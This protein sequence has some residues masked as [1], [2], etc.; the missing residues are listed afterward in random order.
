MDWPAAIPAKIAN[1]ALAHEESLRIRL[2][3][4]AG[5]V[6]RIASGP[7]NVTFC[8]GPDGTLAE[9]AG[10]AVPT[11]VLTIQPTDIAAL[12]HDPARF[13]EFVR[14]E[15]DAALAATIRDVSV[16]MP[17][18]VEQ[19][20]SDAFGAIAG[21]RLADAGRSLLGL[22]EY[23]ASRFH[24]SVASYVRDEAELVAGDAD[25]DAFG[26]DVREISA[27]VDDLAARIDRIAARKP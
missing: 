18:F 6:F 7:A 10:D 9:G 24:A 26:D 8:V 13:G 14:A 22:P 16:T 2:A 11:L 25:V 12:L 15:G 21:Q 20:F 5:G 19:M 17:W 23:A 1:R 27:R 3:A 4:H